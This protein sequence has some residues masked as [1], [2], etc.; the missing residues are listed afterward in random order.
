MPWSQKN[1]KSTYQQKKIKPMTVSRGLGT[2]CQRSNE[3]LKS[4]VFS[5]R[6]KAMSDGSVS[7]CERLYV[8]YCYLH[9]C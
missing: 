3:Q 9:A 4:S 1:F 6:L 8:Y 2:E 5:R 7:T